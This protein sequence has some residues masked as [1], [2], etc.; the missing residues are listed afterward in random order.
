MF[1]TLKTFVNTWECDENNHLN[2]QFY[3]ERFENAGLHFRLQAGLDSNLIG[4]PLSRHV[5]YHRECYVGGLQIVRSGLF[6]H[7]DG[8]VS[9]LHVLYDVGSETISAT[10]LDRHALTPASA[11]AL[12]AKLVCLPRPAQ[13]EQLAARP[14]SFME[15][16]LPGLEITAE[17]VIRAGGFPSYYGS[18]KPAHCNSDSAIDTRHIIAMMSDGA[19]HV[20]ETAPMTRT[21]LE[22]NNF[23]RVAVEMRLS[24]GLPVPA[25]TLTRV[26]TKWRG[27]ENTTFSFRHHLFDATNGHCHAIVETAALVMDLERRKAVPLSDDHRT[28]IR[29]LA[30]DTSAYQ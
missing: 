22:H 20:W 27:A 10:A 3:F 16:E 21:W 28:A 6:D 24:L 11:E 1:E 17:D 13:H 25:G 18:V 12:A 14:R 7:G 15:P 4:A 19:A 5:R 8:W 30:N 29:K 26:V 9:F 23:G 2:V